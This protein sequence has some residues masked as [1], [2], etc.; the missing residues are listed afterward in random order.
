MYVTGNMTKKLY[1]SKRHPKNY[2]YYLITKTPYILL[3]SKVV[4]RN[5]RLFSFSE[6]KYVSYGLHQSQR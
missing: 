5:G 2:S 4:I 1:C 6:V 3:I